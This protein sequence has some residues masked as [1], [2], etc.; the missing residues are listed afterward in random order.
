MELMI[1]TQGSNGDAVLHVAAEFGSAKIMRHLLSELS[2]ESVRQLME[3]GGF[4]DGRPLIRAACNTR[5]NDVIKVLNEFIRDSYNP[6]GNNIIRR[7]LL[8]I[9]LYH[10]VHNDTEMVQTV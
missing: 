1:L 4:D 8:L 3:M 9:Y 5:D 2:A 6:T 7:C 10:M